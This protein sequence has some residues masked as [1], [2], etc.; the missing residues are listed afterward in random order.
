MEAMMIRFLIVTL[1]I[2]ATS[3][4]GCS[5]DSSDSA[6]KCNK[7]CSASAD[8]PELTCTED[9]GTYTMRGCIQNCCV[10]KCP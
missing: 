6:A 4:C 7:S 2:V 10:E 3:I 5:S 9:G 8:C 1:A